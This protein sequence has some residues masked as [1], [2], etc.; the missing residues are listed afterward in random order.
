M[1]FVKTRFFF[2]QIRNI[3]GEIWRFVEFR[4]YSWN[5]VEVRELHR[6]VWEV[7]GKSLECPWEARAVQGKSVG[8]PWEL[9]WAKLPIANR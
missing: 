6:N 5:S 9:R 7:R 4:K 1:N 2:Q 8:N 3:S